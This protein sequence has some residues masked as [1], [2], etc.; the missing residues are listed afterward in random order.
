L[1]TAADLTRNAGGELHVVHVA[2]HS[3]SQSTATLSADR[4]IERASEAD[5]AHVRLERMAKEVAI[6]L[7]RIVLHTR[8]GRADL[9]IAQLAQDIGADMLVVGAGGKSR[10]E[11]LVL[12]SVAESLVRNAPCP[13]LAHRPKSVPAWDQIQPPCPDC[14]AVQQATKRAHFWC[15]RH[16]QH[17]PRAHTYSELPSTYAVGSQTFRGQ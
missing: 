5:A 13:V 16:E 14:I 2:A 6:S 4:P 17:H 3:P 12:G 15:D 11:R 8:V 7:P 1:R 10:L 9:E